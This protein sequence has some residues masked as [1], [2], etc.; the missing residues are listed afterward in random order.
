MYLGLI[1]TQRSRQC[2]VR[3]SYSRALNAGWHRAVGHYYRAHTSYSASTK[4]CLINIVKGVKSD[5]SKAMLR[6]KY[7]NIVD[8]QCKLATTPKQTKNNGKA[9][10]N[11]FHL[12]G[13]ERLN[14]QQQITMFKC[15]VVYV[16][17]AF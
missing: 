14:I 10:S 4:K 8:Y 13:F 15:Y 17:A 7:F 5:L 9:A 2:C 16:V 1:I 6:I 12:Q 11:I 3:G